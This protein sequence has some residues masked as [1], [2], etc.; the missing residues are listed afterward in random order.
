MEICEPGHECAHFDRPPLLLKRLADVS[1]TNDLK[2]LIGMNRWYNTAIKRQIE[3]WEK[4]ASHW[5]HCRCSLEHVVNCR[6]K[7]I[8]MFWNSVEYE[9]FL[10]SRS[11]SLR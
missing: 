6:T 3:D 4:L 8:R 7:A 9:Q 2:H 11:N 5:S 10:N 1:N